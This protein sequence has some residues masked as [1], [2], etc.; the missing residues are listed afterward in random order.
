MSYV[1]L[2]SGKLEET[3]NEKCPK[4]GLK[5]VSVREVGDQGKL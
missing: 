1:Y 3:S 4:F 5:K 2:K